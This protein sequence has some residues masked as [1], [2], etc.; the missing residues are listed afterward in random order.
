VVGKLVDAEAEWKSGS[1]TDVFETE[2]MSP[3][4]LGTEKPA[5]HLTEN[6]EQRTQGGEV[7][8]DD[9]LNKEPRYWLHERH[10]GDFERSFTFPTDVK[11]DEMKA[12]LENGLLEMTVPKT[13]HAISDTKRIPVE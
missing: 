6:G 8:A 10:T 1:N 12:R 4:V 11:P 5:K 2:S 3:R 13:V 7:L 9:H